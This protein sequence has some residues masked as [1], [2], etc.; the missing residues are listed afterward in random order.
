MRRTLEA[1]HFLGRTTLSSRTVGSALLAAFS[2]TTLVVAACGSEPPVSEPA[3]ASDMVGVLEPIP[4]TALPGSPADAV[5][6]DAAAISV[7]AVDVAGLA[8]LLDDAGFVGGTERLFSRAL[9]GRR[10]TLARALVFETAQGAQLYLR[11]LASHVEDVIGE[12]ELRL[13]LAPVESLFVHE[14]NPCCHNETRIILAMWQDGA[15]VLTLEIG[16][17]SARADAVTELASRLDAAV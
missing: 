15:T 1:C 17:Q 6:L 3:G 10:R 8:S 16:G 5:E 7:D 2:V 13:A 4:A 11:W 12:A 9:P 14:P